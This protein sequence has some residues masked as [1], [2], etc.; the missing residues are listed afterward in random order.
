MKKCRKNKTVIDLKIGQRCD[1][2]ESEQKIFSQGHDLDLQHRDVTEGRL[3][4]FF[5]NVVR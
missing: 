3:F 1:V 2:P 5:S 4:F